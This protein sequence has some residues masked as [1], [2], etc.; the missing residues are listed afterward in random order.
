MNSGSKEV[1]R[2]GSVWKCRVYSSDKMRASGVTA[3][4]SMIKRTEAQYNVGHRASIEAVKSDI[5]LDT[6]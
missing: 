1:G 3:I 5:Q 4:K 6:A 2:I